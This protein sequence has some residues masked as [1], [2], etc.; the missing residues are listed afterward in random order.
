M[1]MQ[2]GFRRAFV[3]IIS[4]KL[5]FEYESVLSRREHMAQSGF[6]K[7]KID[8]VLAA[9]LKVASQIELGPYREPASPD[10]NDNHVLSLA[11]YGRA[12]GI[13]TFNTR[14]FA[15]PATELGVNLYTAAEALQ[16]VRR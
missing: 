7:A 10:P 12:D 6:T 9:I 1:L 2:F 15:A 8:D 11:K 16:I 13:V 14:H 3:W 4:A 5:L